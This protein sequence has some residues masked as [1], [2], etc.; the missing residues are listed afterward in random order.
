MESGAEAKRSELGAI[1]EVARDPS[2]AE[3]KRNALGATAEVACDPERSPGEAERARGKPGGSSRSR[4]G[5]KRSETRSGQPRRLL[6]ILSGAQAKQSV[7][8]AS[9]EVPRDPERS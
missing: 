8:G 2:G 7:L 5:R 6:A 1:L 3:A 4:A 9:L